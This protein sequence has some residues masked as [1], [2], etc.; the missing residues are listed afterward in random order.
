M[1]TFKQRVEEFWAW[2]P[3]VAERFY[4]AIELGAG[5]DLTDET[6]AFMEQTMPGM[7]WTFGPG[8]NGGHSFTVTGEG[9]VDKQL[10]AEAWGR[11]QVKVPGWTFYTSRQPRSA[12]SLKDVAI[13]LGDGEQI[14]CN[15]FQ[16]ATEVDDE[17]QRVDIV[18]WHPALKQVPDRD[19]FQILFLLLDEALGEYGTQSTIGSIDIG[20]ISRRSETRSLAELPAFIDQVANSRGWENLPPTESV[21]V[22][23]LD[24]QD[25]G[26]RGDTVIGS[27]VIPGVIGDFLDA[28]GKLPEDPLDGT[29]AQF[30][31]LAMPTSLFPDGQQVQRRSE[32]EDGL[33]LALGRHHSGQAL[34]GAFGRDEAYIDLLILDGETSLEIIDRTMGEL[35]LHGQYQLR[36]FA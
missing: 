27:T 9:V 24:G 34:G 23:Q 22:Y 17:R 13:A 33:T 11:Q 20:K 21:S 15:S 16:V 26:P 25:P 35:D 14:D 36:W 4:E 18:A 2:F 7:A 10:L 6:V 30:G 12:D 8:E 29:G 5:A 19:R 3:T 31:Y 32:I 28:Q 1:T